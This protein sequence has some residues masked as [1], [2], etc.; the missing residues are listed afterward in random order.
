MLD[1]PHPGTILTIYTITC[2]C[3]RGATGSDRREVVERWNRMASDPADAMK[4]REWL[5][6]CLARLERGDVP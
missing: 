6:G 5:A 3:G 2:D 4:S 1:T